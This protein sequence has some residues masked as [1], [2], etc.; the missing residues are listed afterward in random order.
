M[1]II[2][3]GVKPELLMP[4]KRPP[5]Y[6]HKPWLNQSVS[7]LR[8]A[9]ASLYDWNRNDKTEYEGTQIP[10]F[11]I[12]LYIYNHESKCVPS[13]LLLPMESTI[14]KRIWCNIYCPMR[15]NN[16]DGIICVLCDTLVPCLHALFGW[17]WS[18]Y[19]LSERCIL[20][21]VPE[22]S[23]NRGEAYTPT[24]ILNN[25]VVVADR[26]P[27]SWWAAVIIWGHGLTPPSPSIPYVYVAAV[28]SSTQSALHGFT[29][30]VPAQRPQ[31]L[32][33]AGAHAA[34]PSQLPIAAGH[35]DLNDCSPD[36]NT[37]IFVLVRTWSI[38]KIQWI[39][40]Q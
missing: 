39:S 6:W 32:S 23:L 27:A 30:P 4:S 35:L 31:S 24:S 21:I 15:M 19:C 2:F 12:I 40:W 14:T 13:P 22:S 9:M 20:S 36:Q 8:R 18:I 33:V 37:L 7:S 25:V 11:K 17:L 10:F 28:Q 34:H 3:S 38:D 29:R 26:W 16:S 5:R 1:I